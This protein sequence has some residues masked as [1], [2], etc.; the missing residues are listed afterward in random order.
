MSSGCTTNGVHLKQCSNFFSGY[1]YQWSSLAQTVLFLCRWSARKSVGQHR[2]PELPP[3]CLGNQYPKYACRY[4]PAGMSRRFD[5][6]DKEA[7]R[8]WLLH[9]NLPCSPLRPLPRS[10][11]RLGHRAQAKVAQIVTDEV[12]RKGQYESVPPVDGPVLGEDV[13]LW[14]DPS[15]FRGGESRHGATIDGRTLNSV[16]WVRQVTHHQNFRLLILLSMILI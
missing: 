3:R 2:L 6:V 11:H 15:A 1:H 7:L 4:H 5:P 14:A 10:R 8:F 9:S 12:R 16:V 13:V